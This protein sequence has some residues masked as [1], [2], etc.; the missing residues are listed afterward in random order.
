MTVFSTRAVR[1]VQTMVACLPSLHV[2]EVPRR[3][4]LW[5]RNSLSSRWTERS[6]NGKHLP[7]SGELH[8]RTF[9]KPLTRRTEMIAFRHSPREP[10]CLKRW[11]DS[12]QGGVLCNPDFVDG[13]RKPSSPA[14][15]HFPLVVRRRACRRICAWLPGL[16]VFLHSNGGPPT[17]YTGNSTCA[18]FRGAGDP[19]IK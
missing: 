13:H 9:E 6:L 18:V 11:Q 16:R 5:S 1:R 3:H 2:L 19:R 7:R 8:W 12:V 17:L 4:A 14:T 10:R 15:E